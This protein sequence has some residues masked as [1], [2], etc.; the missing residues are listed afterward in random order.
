[1]T[2]MPGAGEGYAGE[3]YASAPP[4][5]DVSSSAY[6]LSLVTSEYQTSPKMLAWLPAV[7]AVLESSSRPGGSEVS[8]SRTRGQ[9]APLVAVAVASVIALMFFAAHGVKT[10]GHKVKCA[11]VHCPP[12]VTPPAPAPAPKDPPD[13]TEKLYF[14]L[15]RTLAETPPAEVTEQLREQYREARA[16]YWG[17]QPR[18]SAV[19]EAK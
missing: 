13:Q 3:Q 17:S 11:I 14:G 4:L 19:E 1:M 7:L 16:A 15:K 5:P 6:Y 12:A 9:V 2:L 18:P 8:M 10:V